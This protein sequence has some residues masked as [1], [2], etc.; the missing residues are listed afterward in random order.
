MSMRQLMRK[1]RKV[2]T[3]M[4]KEH[5][6]PTLQ[7]KPP[8]ARANARPFALASAQTIPHNPFLA[9]MTNAARRFVGY[10]STRGHLQSDR[11]PLSTHKAPRIEFVGIMEISGRI[12]D[13]VS[14]H[15][16]QVNG[17]CHNTRHER[18]S[19]ASPRE[20]HGAAYRKPD[21]GKIEQST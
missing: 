1:G 17:W 20:V 3:R 8:I 16:G 2:S 10:H 4:S 12:R 18:K 9:L 19:S 11:F 14:K 7:L 21:K 5:A 6:S 13:S 15:N